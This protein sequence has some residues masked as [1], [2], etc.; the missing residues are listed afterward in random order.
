MLLVHRLGVRF[1]PRPI[2]HSFHECHL[3]ASA[4][5]SGRTV[6]VTFDCLKPDDE[7]MAILRVSDILRG[8]YQFK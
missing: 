8:A 2:E 5:T 6:G 3:H 1:L 4:V 7:Q